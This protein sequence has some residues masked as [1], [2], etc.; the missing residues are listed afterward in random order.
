MLKFKERE[1]TDF[2]QIVIGDCHN[3]DMNTLRREAKC[4][5]DFDVPWHYLVRKDGTIE[6][7]RDDSAP[8]GH[9]L[10]NC[11]TSV[12]ILVDMEPDAGVTEKQEEAY[13]FIRY[14]WPEASMHYMKVEDTEVPV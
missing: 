10:P 11:D 5:G 9:M 12:Y 8:A 7:G 2:V 14:I 1:R 4:R 3:K 13:T 6:K